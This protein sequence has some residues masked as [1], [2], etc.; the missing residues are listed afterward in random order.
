MKTS[1]LKAAVTQIYEAIQE[2]EPTADKIAAG[3]HP[4]FRL[5]AKIYTATSYSVISTCEKFTIR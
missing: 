5:S 1:Q 4:D 2:G 3:V